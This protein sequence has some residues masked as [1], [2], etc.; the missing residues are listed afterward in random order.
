VRLTDSNLSSHEYDL[1]L[2]QLHTQ[3]NIKKSEHA[4]N[5]TSAWVARQLS[6]HKDKLIQDCRYYYADSSPTL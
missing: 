4:K 5:L 6:S 1:T 3:I 2:A